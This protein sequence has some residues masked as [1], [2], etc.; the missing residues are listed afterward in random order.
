MSTLEPISA[1]ENSSGRYSIGNITI[2]VIFIITLVAFLNAAILALAWSKKPF[3]GFVVEPTMV[4]SDVGGASWN[5]QRIGLSHPERIIQIGEQFVSSLE[6][7]E[8]VTDR[9]SIGAPVSIQTTFPDGSLR[10]YPS[11][12]VMVFPAVDLARFFWLPFFIGLAYLAIGFWIYRMRGDVAS[13]RAFA[14]FCISAALATGLYFDLISTHILSALWTIAIAFLGGTLIGLA[15]V[16]P[17]E[18]SAGIRQV[19]FRVLPYLLSL[20]LAV[21]GVLALT[22]ESNPWAYVDAWR[23]SYIYTSIGIFFFLGTMFYRQFTNPSNAVRQ[24]AR[25]VLWGS[26]IAFLPIAVWMLAPN[27]GLVIPWNPGFFMP[28][29]IFFPISIAIAILRYRLWD[30][31]VIVNRTLVYG[32]LII[33]L[34]LIYVASIVVLQR[35]FQALTGERSDLAAVVSTLVIVALFIPVRRYVQ[36][37]VDRRFYRSRYD[38]VKT[39]ESFS[40]SLRDEVDLERVILRLENVIQETIFPAKVCTWLNTGT[41]FQIYRQREGSSSNGIEQNADEVLIGLDDPILEMFDQGPGTIEMAQLDVDSDAYQFMLSSGYMLI[42]PLITQGELIGW[43]NLGQRMSEQ[44]YTTDDEILLTRLAIQVAPTVRVAQLVAEQQVEAITRE[45]LEQE[46]LVASR[47]QTGLLPKELP[48]FDD[49]HLSAYYQPAREVGG[50]F[51]EFKYFKDGRLGIFIGDVTDKGIPAAMVM[52]TTRTLLLA[53]AQESLTPDQVLKQ[54][55]N[56]LHEDIPAGMFVTCFYAILDPADGKIVF[57]NAGHNLPYRLTDHS[58]VE[59]KAAGM[60]LGM[61][62]DIEYDLHKL[63][64]EPGD[65]VIFYSDGLVEAHNEKREMFGA[66]RLKALFESFTGGDQTLID[67]LMVELEMFTGSDLEQEDDIT[68]VGVKRYN[69]ADGS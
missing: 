68:I 66:N 64:V 1:G 38:A 48:Q 42:V 21:W 69:S 18:W 44:N 3:L 36:E 9:L 43:I 32:L 11:V 29:L 67:H 27:L 56:L 39:V 65:F 46:L 22:D 50:D 8:T 28:F 60:P 13:S 31:D 53:V 40:A 37:F 52:A 45:R 34:V 30:I 54:V 6:E 24:Q 49:W 10:V 57:A 25:I 2:M 15:L 33:V 51:Y 12:R 47:I 59:M 58:V 7:Y 4:V 23:L 55:N 35:T 17:E 61:M 41:G 26:L 62:P 14:L 20:G 5:I 16:F 19:V 63:T